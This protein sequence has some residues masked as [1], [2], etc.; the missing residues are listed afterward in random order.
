MNKLEY[1]IK[2]NDIDRTILKYI[3]IIL[4]NV[5]KSRI[6]KLFRNKDIKIN[7]LR[8]IEKSYKL[9]RN[10]KIEIFGIVNPLFKEN[11]KNKI[12][13]NFDIIFENDDIL[14]VDKPTGI[15][16]HS[17]NNSLDE[18]VLKYLNFKK[19]DS[20][21]PSHIGRLDK[22]TSGLVVY[23]KKYSVLIELLEKQKNFKKI[24]SFLPSCDLEK[25]DFKIVQN[26][27]KDE[28]NQKMKIS[29][30][31]KKSITKF[32]F[33]KK[34]NRWFAELVTGRKH[35]IRLILS[36]NLNCPIVGEKKYNNLPFKEKIKQNNKRLFLHSHKIIFQ[37]LSKNLSY[38]NNIS[39]VSKIP[40]NSK[41]QN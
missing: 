27:Q 10:D 1:I 34:R 6:E 32:Y 4:E 3:S 7:G 22:E 38:L 8:N 12:E 2:E 30:F 15:V 25:K 16:M 33:L 11:S 39:F 21:T 36:E 5:P 18:Q 41:I 24:Y 14:I 28:K 13:K 35:Q 17:E 31:G 37:D 19:V 29:K 9:K 20:F 40:W 23:A 26:V